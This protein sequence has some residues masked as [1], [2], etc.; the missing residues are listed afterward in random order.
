MK[1][2][3]S[4]LSLQ[5]MEEALSCMNEGNVW[6]NTAL[7]PGIPMYAMK[8]DPRASGKEESSRDSLIIAIWDATP[9]QMN[10][11]YSNQFEIICRLAGYALERAGLTQEESRQ[12]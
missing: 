12:A 7:A 10:D 2:K 3:T 8:I 1:I 6:R 11:Y 5:E 9:E 4:Y